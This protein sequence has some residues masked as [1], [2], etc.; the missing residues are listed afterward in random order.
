MNCDK[1]QPKETKLKALNQIV[2]CNVRLLACLAFI[3]QTLNIFNDLNLVFRNSL[4]KYSNLPNLANNL[5]FHTK[6]K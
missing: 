6:I 1:I 5:T 2:V 4:P 3:N